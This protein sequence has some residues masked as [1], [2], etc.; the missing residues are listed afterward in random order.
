MTVSMAKSQP[1]KTN[2]NAQI[3]LNTTFSYDN[4][5]YFL[6]ICKKSDASKLAVIEDCRVKLMMSFLSII[7]S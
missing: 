6:F 3:Y 4:K 5:F 2:P 1:R 7:I